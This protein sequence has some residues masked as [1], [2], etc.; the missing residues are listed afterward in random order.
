MTCL[1]KQRE[2]HRV[3][4]MS[5]LRTYAS[6][7][8]KRRTS[9]NVVSALGDLD[10]LSLLDELTDSLA[11]AGTVHLQTIHNGVDG[12]ELHLH[13]QSPSLHITLGTSASSLS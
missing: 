6:P 11:S 13:A 3:I 10:D 4:N 9:Q 12:D 1:F 5:L 2:K 7:T 8:L